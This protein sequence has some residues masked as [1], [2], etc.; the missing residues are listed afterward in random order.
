MADKFE[1]FDSIPESTI[2]IDSAGDIVFTNSAWARFSSDNKGSDSSTGIKINYLKVCEQVIG[3]EKKMATEAKLGIEQV[4]KKEQDIFELEYPCHSPTE[5]K[6][7]ILRA[8]RVSTNPEF[9]LLTHIDIT[10][11]KTAEI[12]LERSYNKSLF[13]NERLNNTLH[14]IVHDIQSP[15]TGISGL[16]ELSKSES[17]LSTLS[18]Y[19]KVIGQGSDRVHKYIKDMLKHLSAPESIEP[20]DVSELVTQFI[21][22]I[23]S[24]LI[25]NKIETRVNIKQAGEFV[26]NK[27]EF[28][29]VLSNLVGNAAK[30]RD[31]KK[32]ENFI[33]IS[34]LSDDSGAVLIVK[35]N[36]IGI[37]EEHLPKLMEY[38]Y[39]ADKESADG[40]GF[41][42]F[43]VSQ[44]LAI[45]G[46]TVELTSK[47][48][49]GTEFRIELPARIAARKI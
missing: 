36:G 4:I 37:E 45:I 18:N 2:I 23:E 9:T 35:D 41:G 11:R 39:K 8:S 7:F 42:L 32:D 5:N 34:F 43:M 10:K 20:I 16:I 28:R 15:V 19:L 25:L 24:L 6:W 44:S 14:K 13:L 47:F 46:G 33:E 27:V 17:D 48:G 38:S 30:Y 40:E 26:S 49:V 12:E 22:S 31:V 29:S 21:I 1:L 3:D